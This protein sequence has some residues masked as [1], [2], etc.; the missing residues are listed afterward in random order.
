MSWDDGGEAA[1]WDVDK[2]TEEI[3]SWDQDLRKRGTLATDDWMTALCNSVEVPNENGQPGMLVSPGY[4]NPKRAQIE[5][6]RARGGLPL[7][8][9]GVLNQTAQLIQQGYVV[10][11]SENGTM[12]GMINQRDLKPSL[13]PLPNAIH[14]EKIKPPEFYESH[15]PSRDTVLALAANKSITPERAQSV[16][17]ALD[18]DQAR[19]Q[20]A[21]MKTNQTKNAI[22]Q[23]P[24]LDGDPPNGLAS[25]DNFVS[26]IPSDHAS[27]TAPRPATPPPVGMSPSS[28][29]RWEPDP[30]KSIEQ[31]L[32]ER[33]EFERCHGPQVP[34]VEE[35]PGAITQ[36]SLFRR[37]SED[38]TRGSATKQVPDQDT[39]TSGRN[40]SPWAELER[41]KSFSKL[42]APA[43]QQP[44]PQQPAPRTSGW[45]DLMRPAPQPQV[46]Q[47]PAPLPPQVN[48][49]E[50]MVRDD[51]TNA[52]ALLFHITRHLGSDEWIAWELETIEEMLSR[53]GFNLTPI[54]V[55]KLMAAKVVMNSEAYF[56]S[57]RAFEKVTVAWSN[58]AVDMG[59][60]Q[61]VSMAEMVAVRLLI[62]THLRADVE[63]SDEVA[64]FV[65]ASAID[66]GFALLPAP[67]EFASVPFVNMVLRQHGNVGFAL[68]EQVSD[69]YGKLDRTSD[70]TLLRSF[71]GLSE[72]V[73]V[74]CQRLLRIESYAQDALEDANE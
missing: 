12:I 34:T 50:S 71:L 44:A 67:L 72:T 25:R 37:I 11:N 66:Q 42:A 20:A 61:P 27:Q 49:L 3:D 63:F 52:V 39:F 48:P 2:S 59:M 24:S 55:D 47:A 54:N 14:G 31:Q 53:D 19:K 68:A 74:Q 45:D 56:R 33:L 22:E 65:A 1:D 64:Q 28:G 26:H 23:L 10:A 18:A 17:Q 69:A 6:Q 30:N 15:A 73:S 5:R 21:F 8:R 62:A 57:A 41:G 32:R 58:R 29:P 16:L 40:A 38:L 4:F 9:D 51:S 13:K 35:Q 60:M 43:P 46:Q 7:A 70:S 36:M